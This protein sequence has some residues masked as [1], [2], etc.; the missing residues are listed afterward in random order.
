MTVLNVRFKK[1]LAK[2]ERVRKRERK[3]EKEKERERERERGRERID[4]KRNKTQLLFS[5]MQKVVTI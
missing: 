4:S 1:V 3:R 2:K 5:E